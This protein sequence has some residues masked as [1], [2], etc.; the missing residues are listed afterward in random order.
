MLDF[1]D[2]EKKDNTINNSL[3]YTP[4]YLQN[5]ISEKEINNAYKKILSSL[6]KDEKKLYLLYYMQNK[7]LKD[8]AKETGISYAAVKKHRKKLKK[9]L[10]KLIKNDKFLKYSTTTVFLLQNFICRVDFFIIL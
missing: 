7:K 1:F 4:D 10:L 2:N 6:S 3:Y 8:I 9:N 5:M